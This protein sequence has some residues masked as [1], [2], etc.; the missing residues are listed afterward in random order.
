MT[1]KE[2][3]KSIERTFAVGL[4]ICT[5]KNADY[6]GEDDPFK[7]FKS[8]E[9]VG[10]PLERAILVRVLDKLSRVSNLLD[11]EAAVADESIEDTLIDMINYLA[12]LKAH[13]ESKT[14]F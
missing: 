4:D 13:R 14:P 10:V 12:I 2:F 1:T 9:V 8:A 5:K 7:N 6:A 11:K 3:L